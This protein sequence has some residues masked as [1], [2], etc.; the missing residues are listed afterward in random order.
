MESTVSPGQPASRLGD[1][2][3]SSLTELLV[4]MALML[5]FM[6]IFTGAVVMMNR[7]VT[8]V[9]SVNRSSTELNQAFLTLD[10][11]VRYAA[12]ISSPAKGTD[13]NWYVELRTTATGVQVCTQLRIELAGL[14][15]QRRS[16]QVTASVASGLTT[17]SELAAGVVNGSAAAGS[18]D[19]PFLLKPE[20]GT[21]DYQQLV[22]KLVSTAGAGP[23]LTTSRSAVSFTA[24]NSTVPPPPAI[25]QE[26]AR[27]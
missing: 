5:V 3:G 2:R 6:S 16:W 11:T 1:D 8:K 25:C 17:W 7:S 23:T 24:L 14:R 22:V 10:K 20:T 26:V 12:A 4:G 13:G 19:Q 27:S 9:E 21:V 15:L 18:D